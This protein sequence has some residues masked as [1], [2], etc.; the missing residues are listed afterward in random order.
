M[1]PICRVADAKVKA[2]VEAQRCHLL[3]SRLHFA[4]YPDAAGALVKNFGLTCA[5]C[6]APLGGSADIDHKDPKS[7]IGSRTAWDNFL[8]SC[9]ACNGAKLTAILPWDPESRN[10]WEDFKYVSNTDKSCVLVDLRDR[11]SKKLSV[12]RFVSLQRFIVM[13]HLNDRPGH[14]SDRKPGF[15]APFHAAPYRR[16]AVFDLAG[17]LVKAGVELEEMVRFASCTG[18]WTVW[19]TALVGLCASASNVA[20]VVYHFGNS[21]AFP[22]TDMERVVEAIANGW[23]K[24]SSSIDMEDIKEEL[25]KRLP[26]WENK[27]R[28]GESRQALLLGG[29][30]TKKVQDGGLMTPTKTVNNGM[31]VDYS[32]KRVGRRESLI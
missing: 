12:K 13:F 5:Y 3:A 8:L 7:G 21:S 32:P 4:N 1:R 26:G 24:T 2:W 11:Y 29:K 22:G 17:T 20:D 31:V 25:D 10:F 30:N 9:R 15:I 14:T 28:L 16:K 23:L 6:E 18:F 27:I 19:V